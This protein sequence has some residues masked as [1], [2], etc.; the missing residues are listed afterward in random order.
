[1]AG[2]LFLG[3]AP[4]LTQASPAAAVTTG[5]PLNLPAGFRLVTEPSGQAQY[6]FTDF[7]V[8]P[9]GSKFTTGKSGKVAWVSADQSVVRTI[10]KLPA[11][12]SM[13]VGLISVQPA[14]DYTSSGNLYFLYPYINADGH[15][16]N[17]IA[18]YT[19]DDVSNPT[20]FSGEKVILDKINQDYPY[21]GAG[22]VIPNADGTFYAGF[23]D[24]GSF[25]SAQPESLRAQDLSDPHGK[26]FRFDAQGRGLP[27]NPFYEPANPS[28]W[29]SRVFAYGLRNPTRFSV[30]ARTGH[31]Y[32]GDVG[33][34][35]WEEVNV[36]VGG[37]NFGWPC[38][39]GANIKTAGF[40]NMAACKTMYASGIR[41]DTPLYSWP[42]N[43]AG[44]A[45]IGGMFYTG[46]SY[47][48]VYRGKYFW[49]DYAQGVLRII[50][51]DMN[52]KVTSAG[53][54]FA[55]GVGAPVAIH[56]MLNGDLAYADILSG[57]IKRLRYESG[58]RPPTASATTQ[59]DPDTLTVSVDASAS[60]DLDGD[61]LTYSVTYGDGSTAV[62]LAK[63][64]HTYA[65]AGTYPVTVVVSDPLGV[66]DTLTMQ[67]KPQ[68]HSPDLQLT[69]PPPGQRFA[70]GSPVDVSA[71]ATDAED[72]PLTP[73]FDIVLQHCPSGGVCHAHP[74]TSLDGS[75]YSGIFTEHGGDTKM[76]I[77]VS[78]TDS[79]GTKV[80]K[81][82]EALPDVHKLTVVS[83]AP[84][85][86]D[87]DSAI[88]YPAV[89][90]QS[91]S[92]SVPGL[93]GGRQF[94]GWSDGGDREH[95]ITMPA[96]DLILTAKYAT[97][98]DTKY[99]Q[100]G[101]E[102]VLGAATSQETGY[103]AGA[104]AGG[105]YR[106]YANGAIMWS[107]KTGAHVVK[108]SLFK[109]YWEP[110]NASV[111][112]F[113]SGDEVKL[114]SGYASYFER[115]NEYYSGG[116]GAHFVKGAVLTRYLALGATSFGYPISDEQK[117]LDGKGSY[118]NFTN[119]RSIFWSPTTGA[120]DVR[121]TLRTK[122][123]LM[124]GERSCL[125]YPTS[126]EYKTATGLR[127]NFQRGYITYTTS[128]KSTVAHCG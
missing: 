5:V 108:G 42:H 69:T 13:D 119:N 20:A 118:S 39:E 59:N 9:D 23:G 84:A 113:P 122:Y 94:A 76:A 53:A 50:G 124:A 81:L 29:R 126:G 102:A 104:L 121:G 26:I 46:V 40:L 62:P 24:E 88:T 7:A 28:S 41:H 120:W 110:G 14:P 51:T 12:G 115:G 103:T 93:S 8:M 89:A 47:P 114:T 72:G 67:V 80:S 44:A 71:T 65:A 107:R 1:M 2:I 61:P 117:S 10:T 43:G 64:H 92:V 112:G 90:G 31:L 30:D 33:W 68:N 78:V 17:R 35:L 58:N 48:A 36:A 111:Y 37:E 22:T 95:S 123:V 125:G 101:G 21:H 82:Y 11:F 18:R 27:S 73:K 87:N 106:T 75:S 79:D 70:V 34:Q 85:L 96:A 49:A 77:T 4:A 66:K 100:Y 105:R 3:M 97:E 15:K 99:A 98:I 56:P 127:N 83:P 16:Y 74:D 91:V 86:I 6:D 25:V 19:V 52:D 63:S 54:L 55:S 128:S 60:E 57:S 32:I 116:S 45:S 38:Y 109:H